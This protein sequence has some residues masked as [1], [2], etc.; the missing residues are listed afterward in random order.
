MAA[1]SSLDAITL[2]PT[3]AVQDI[4]PGLYF[5]E[6]D[7]GVDSPEALLEILDEAAFRPLN[8]TRVR[9]GYNQ[10]PHW[11]R[12][13]LHGSDGDRSRILELT[14]PQLLDVTLF[15]PSPDG[16]YERQKSGVENPVSTRPFLALRPNFQLPTLG[17]DDTTCY[18]LV[19]H[20]GTLRFQARVLSEE[21]AQ[22]YAHRQIVFTYLLAGALLG[23]A[24][25]N[26]CLFRGLRQ[27]AHGWLFLL[28]LT[29]S[30]NMVTRSGALHLL[31]WVPFSS[32]S[33]RCLTIS[34]LT[35]LF[36]AIEFS[37]AYLRTREHSP[38]LARAA[39]IYG[40]LGICFAIA[41]VET[42][43]AVFFGILAC[44]LGTPFLI[45]FLAIRAMKYQ[46]RASVGWFMISWGVVLIGIV[47]FVFVYV[48]ILPTNFFTLN[49]A[50][51][52]TLGASL[53]WAFTLTRHVKQQEQEHRDMLEQR[54]ADRT[55]SLKLALENV[56]TL[57][58]LLPVCCNCKNIRDDEGIWQPMEVYVSRRT[59]ADFSHGICPTCSKSLYPQERA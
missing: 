57:E 54:V 12:F 15:V 48:D 44:A 36:I 52:A 8:D 19:H 4:T 58:G 16:G 11:F 50:H 29:T 39:T 26:L 2:S 28:L 1:A 31:L 22:R 47:L 27:R 21:F 37:L 59:N 14:N 9:F 41:G 17:P 30:I 5:V 10:E 33:T 3:A 51:V 56:R 40:L 55:A 34:G 32:W 43:Q 20:Y 13:T 42:S 25:Y 46:N 18:L 45:S 38:R 53:V 24:V 7:Q 35:T 49:F 23:L 6:G